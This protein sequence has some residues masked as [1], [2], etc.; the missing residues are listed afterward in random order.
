MPYQL[1]STVVINDDLLKYR[2]M[3]RFS[4]C[5][6][7][8]WLYGSESIQFKDKIFEKLRTD[9][10]FVRDWRT[11]TMDESRQI[12]NRRWK[13]LLKYNFITFDGLKTN[14]ERFVDFTEVLE[15]YDQGLAA[16]FYI[17]AIFYV[18]VLSMGTNRHQQILEKCMKNEVLPNIT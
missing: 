9:N 17:N 3:A 5:D 13:Q 7:Q 10:V 4:W 1:A 11:V 18:T 6:L 16:K 14:P 15:S 8:E 2:R 12:C